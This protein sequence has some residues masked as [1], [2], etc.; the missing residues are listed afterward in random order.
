MTRIVNPFSFQGSIGNL[1]YFA[2]TIP[3]FLTQHLVAWLGI[4]AQGGQMKYDELFY[5]IPLRWILVSP[6]TLPYWGK[7]YSVALTLLGIAVVMLTAWALL[8]LS[9][10]RSVDANVPGWVAGFAIVPVAQ[11]LII[12]VLWISPPAAPEPEPVLQR[13]RELRNEARRGAF[14]GMLIGMALTLAGVALSALVFGTYGTGIFLLMPFVIGTLVGY[15]ANRHA[16][17][18]DGETARLVF[19]ATLLGS[20]ALL[21]TALEG[22]G[23]LIM[24]APIGAVAALIGGVIGRQIAR[25]RR[26]SG[27]RMAASV[28]MLPIVF[29]IEAAFPPSVHFDTEQTITVQ[30]P[31]ERVWKAIVQ[32]ETIEE[33]LS[34]L[35][36]FGIAYPVRG[37]VFGAGVGALRYGDFST[38]TAIERVTQWQENSKLAFVV[39]KDIPGLR[40]LSPY[41]HVHA[42]HVQGYFTTRETS[43]EL[44]P[45]EGGITEIVERTSHQL[46]L[47]PALYWLPFARHMVDTN[48]ARVLRHIKRQAERSEVATI[49]KR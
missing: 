3:I 12:P 7:A 1:A 38:G 46:K 24:A 13:S 17:L 2:W 19:G 26:D 32:M 40:E 34:L 43:F 30:A 11:I 36:K 4:R 16:E 44:I 9:Y 27:G 8:A 28:A 6:D 15:V 31:P 33:P 39:L 41:A 25:S 42:P 47:D 14:Q 21:V 10:R 22:V 5:A 37:R 18:T 20:L 48:N 29:A 49:A 23:C 45:R 35:H